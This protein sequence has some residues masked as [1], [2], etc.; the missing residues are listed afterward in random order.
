[1]SPAQILLGS[2]G[3]QRLVPKSPLIISGFKG[4]VQEREPLLFLELLVTFGKHEANEAPEILEWSRI[5]NVAYRISISF[6]SL[7]LSIKVMLLFKKENVE[8]TLNK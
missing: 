1:M 6:K 2:F 7:I 4:E 8:M 5:S 3:I